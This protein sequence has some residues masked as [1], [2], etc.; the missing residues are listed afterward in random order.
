MGLLGLS[1]FAFGFVGSSVGAAQT[2]GSSLGIFENRSDVGS[3]TLPGTATFDAATGVY[4][5][6]SAGEDLWANV[7]EFHFVWKKV[8][9]D[10]S[11]TADVNVSDGIATSHPHRKALLMFR[12]TLDSDALFAV[13]AI[14]GSGE[15]ALQDPGL[16]RR[17][18][19]GENSCQ[20]RRQLTPYNSSCQDAMRSLLT[21]TDWVARRKAALMRLRGLRGIMIVQSTTRFRKV[22]RPAGYER[23]CGSRVQV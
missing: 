13:A 1:A 5:I 14:H 18:S 9:G 21:P 2:D 15:T 17:S 11:L 10:V 23:S 7:D 16:S 22:V 3:V 4:T 19:M 6:R 12:Q 8:S 20:I